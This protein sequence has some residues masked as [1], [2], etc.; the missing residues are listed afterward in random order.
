MDRSRQGMTRWTHFRSKKG[1]HAGLGKVRHTQRGKLST[2]A[3]PSP[4]EVIIQTSIWSH[5]Q[6]SHGCQG[7]PG[8]VILSRNEKVVE[9]TRTNWGCGEGAPP[10]RCSEDGKTRCDDDQPP[11]TRPAQSKVQRWTGSPDPRWGGRGPQIRTP[12]GIGRRCHRQSLLYRLERQLRA[13]WWTSL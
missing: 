9:T 10:P 3:Y 13:T 7:G 11:G 2:K 12:S 8:E 5:F 4:L 6:Y 1:S